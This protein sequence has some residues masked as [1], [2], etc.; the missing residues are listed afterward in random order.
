M[1]VSNWTMIICTGCRKEIVTKAYSSLDKIIRLSF[2]KVK[3]NLTN[4]L[5]CFFLVSIDFITILHNSFLLF[6]D[7]LFIKLM[8]DKDINLDTGHGD[9]ELSFFLFI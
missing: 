3:Y 4:I 8:I 5:C 9:Y 7:V 2:V 1:R 6:K